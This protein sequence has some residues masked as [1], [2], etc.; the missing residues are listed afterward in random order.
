MVE[1]RLVEF[2]MLTNIQIVGGEQLLK[3]AVDEAARHTVPYT[4]SVTANNMEHRSLTLNI[5]H[6]VAQGEHKVS[7]RLSS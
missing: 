3:R 1:K 5:L 7:G 4:I 2:G 6:G